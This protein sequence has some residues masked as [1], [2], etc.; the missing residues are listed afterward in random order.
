MSSPLIA[1]AGGIIS[2]VALACSSD[3]PTEP[4]TATLPPGCFRLTLGAWSASHEA[5]NPPATLLLYDSVGTDGFERG[6]KIVRPTPRAT[7]TPYPWMWWSVTP[8]DSMFLVF[9]GGFV[10]IDVHLARRAATWEGLA[11]AFTD[12]AP[13]VQARARAELSPMA[14][15]P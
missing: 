9:T 11:Y 15:P 6:R 1:K 13:S 2:L 8:A 5:V 14:C 10:G 7:G 4:G 3:R 12:I